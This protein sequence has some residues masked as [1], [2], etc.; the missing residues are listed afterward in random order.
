MLK[1]TL[2]NPVP[3]EHCRSLP[4]PEASEAGSV[5]PSL[6][7]HL[8]HPAR[9]HD[10]RRGVLNSPPPQNNSNSSRWRTFIISQNSCGPFT[11][12]LLQ[13]LAWPSISLLLL[14]IIIISR[15][16]LF[17]AKEIGGRP[18]YSRWKIIFNGS[19]YLLKLN[20]QKRNPL[21]YVYIDAYWESFFEKIGFVFCIPTNFLDNY[22]KNCKFNKRA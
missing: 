1:W 5:P 2:S 8:V 6:G 15:P 9:G 14:F 17:E 19:I 13:I 16:W 10:G 18:W 21:P 3:Y 7:R 12:L 11:Q 4:R 22:C 20:T